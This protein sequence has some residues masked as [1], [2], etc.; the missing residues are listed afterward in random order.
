MLQTRF[1]INVTQHPLLY[2]PRKY[3]TARF[4]TCI[5]VSYCKPKQS[6]APTKMYIFKQ[7]YTAIIIY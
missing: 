5:F 3:I 7:F 2:I 6:L 4:V 1:I